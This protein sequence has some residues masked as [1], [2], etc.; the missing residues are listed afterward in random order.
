MAE[1]NTAGNNVGKVVEVK[2]VVVDAV[3]TGSLPE[4]YNALRIT[5]PGVNGSAGLDLIAVT[6]ALVVVAC[7]LRQ[8]SG[9]GLR[10]RFPRRLACELGF[11]NRRIIDH[12]LVENGE[13]VFA[14][15]GEGGEAAQPQGE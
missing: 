2:G 1:R 11:A 10:S 3:F 9:P 8:V 4:I 13:Q 6:L 5:V 7:D 14:R 12:G 15:R